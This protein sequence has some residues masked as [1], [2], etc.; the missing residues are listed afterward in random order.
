METGYRK[1]SVPATKIGTYIV[2][3]SKSGSQ[4]IYL[5]KEANF[6][7]KPGTIDLNRTVIK[8]K[9][10]PI[11]AGNKPAISIVS[12]DKYGN[13]LEYDKYKD[14]F[15]VVFIDSNNQEFVSDSSCDSGIKKVFYTSK[16][17]VTIVGDTKVEVTY[18]GTE[19]INTSKIIITIIPGNPDPKNSI[20]SRET[21]SCAFEE[22]TDESSFEIDPLKTLKLNITLYDEYKNYISEIPSNVSIANPI[23]SGNN[24]KKIIFTVTKNIGNFD[25]DFQDNKQYLRIYQHLVK[26]TYDFNLIVL[27]SNENASFHYNM[28]ISSGDNKYGNGDYDIS[29]CVLI[30]NEVNFVAGNYE[31]FKLEL[32][33]S[34]ELLY[35]DNIYLTNDISINNGNANNTSFK[36]SIEKAG[37]DNGIYII[38]I[39]SEKKENII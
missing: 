8:V 24:M 7:I 30:P 22:Y 35:N 15:T 31:K 12:Y 1:Y 19:K 3:T 6:L 14:N 33:T 5:K 4:G 27:S 37:S 10:T 9:V 32:R 13:Q 2:S 38:N 34:N 25:L 23:M 21:N 39:Y 16:E 28:I 18:N 17:E 29:K 36:S 11:Q 26:G 20:L